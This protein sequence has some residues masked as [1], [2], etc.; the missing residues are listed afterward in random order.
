[1]PARDGDPDSL[2][3][4]TEHFLA[5]ISTFRHDPLSLGC[6]FAVVAAIGDVMLIERR[7]GAFPTY[8]DEAFVAKSA[9]GRMLRSHRPLGQSAGR[10]EPPTNEKDARLRAS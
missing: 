7:T 6:G 9:A 8:T 3:A 5:T 10:F 4:E 1:V 2:R